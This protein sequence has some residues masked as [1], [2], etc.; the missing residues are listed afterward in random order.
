MM[1][2][3]CPPF[4]PIPPSFPPIPPH[5]PPFSPIIPHFS[6]FPISPRRLPG[7]G[8]FG[9]GYVGAL[10][11]CACSPLVA[12]SAFTGHKDRFAVPVTP[13]GTVCFPS[14]GSGVRAPGLGSL[15][16][17]WPWLGTSREWCTTESCK[18]LPQWVPCP[19]LFGGMPETQRWWFTNWWHIL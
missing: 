10:L 2:P 9:F 15:S 5:S 11:R 16:E 18:E 17:L 13:R 14:R 6:I 4:P 1:I 7:L 12:E 8:D 19:V 3:H